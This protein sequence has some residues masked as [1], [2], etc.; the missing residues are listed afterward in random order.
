[1]MAHRDAGH[2]MKTRLEPAI[3]TMSTRETPP[4]PGGAR[5]P[6]PVIARPVALSANLTLEAA[7]RRIL[8]NCLE[9]ADANVAGVLAQDAE[10]LHQMRVGLRR[11]RAALD[12]FKS[13]VR[14]PAALR[15]DLDWLSALLGKARDWDVLMA[16]TLERVGGGDWHAGRQTL[17]DSAGPHAAAAH[18][19]LRRALRSRRYKRLVVA[20]SG[21]ILGREWRRPRDGVQA[22]NLERPVR[23]GMRPLLDKAQRRLQ[24]R[25]NNADPGAVTD[26]H[27]V[28][29]AAKKLR[30]A[31]EFFQPLLPAQPLKQQLRLLAA[32]QDGLGRL[33]DLA[34]ADA[35]LAQLARD[36]EAPAPALAYARGYLAAVGDATMKSLRKPL[37]R[38]RGMAPIEG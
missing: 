23:K 26:L 14:L 6:A 3:A 13:K 5:P 19:A 1:M 7:F 18:K 29:I 32:L 10:C 35:L 11:L 20:L 8:Q 9:Q 12:L 22:G 28:R 25:L 38:A 27:Q 30:Y 21:W 2:I 17:R 15:H 33:N 31:A 24:K 34:T 16:Q 4:P 37:R 36:A